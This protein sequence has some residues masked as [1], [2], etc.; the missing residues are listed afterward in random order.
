MSL[1][2]RHFVALSKIVQADY[3]SRRSQEER[4]KEKLRRKCFSSGQGKMKR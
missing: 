1:S 3:Q 4:E 2:L